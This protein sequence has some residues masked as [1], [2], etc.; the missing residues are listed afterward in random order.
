MLK[1]GAS[2]PWEDAL[3]QIAGTR[4][5]SSAS[6]V[7]YMQPLLDYLIEENRKNGEVI[8]WP[9]YTWQPPTDTFVK[10][11]GIVETLDDNVDR[12]LEPKFK[13]LL[14]MIVSSAVFQAFPTLKSLPLLLFEAGAQI[15]Q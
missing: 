11:N 5:M 2:V 9:D 4:K 6:L 7:R 15:E 10:E 12:I 8:G 3:E 1:L 14:P 13:P